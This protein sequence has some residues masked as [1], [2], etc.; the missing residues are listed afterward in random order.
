MKLISVVSKLVIKCGEN[1]SASETQI[2]SDL[3]KKNTQ[4]PRRHQKTRYSGKTPKTHFW[5]TRS[6]KPM[7]NRGLLSISQEVIELES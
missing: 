4:K 3:A 6:V 7:A 1:R 2:L 5:G